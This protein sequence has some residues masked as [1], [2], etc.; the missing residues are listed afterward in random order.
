LLALVG[1]GC[2]DDGTTSTTGTT[3]PST[4]DFIQL[5][6][7]VMPGYGFMVDYFDDPYQERG[8]FTAQLETDLIPDVFSAAGMDYTKL[9][10]DTVPGGYELAVNPSLQT[11]V[12]EDWA[13]ASNTAAALGFVL[14]Q[15]SVLLTDF[16]PSDT[17]NTGYAVVTFP[18]GTLDEKIAGDFFTHAGSVNMGLGGGFA[19]FGDS[20]YFLNIT[21]D[22][23]KPYSELA[24]DVFIAELGKAATGFAGPKATV[25][26]SGRCDARFVGND[27][28]TKPMGDE[29]LAE[30]A[31]LDMAKQDELKG[32]QAEFKTAFDAAVVK[33]GWD[34][35]G[36]MPKRAP[37]PR[38][39]WYGQHFIEIKSN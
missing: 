31:E 16:T 13:A 29:Y 34:M 9:D 4:V 35:P 17:G 20:M 39:G 19:A 11:R 1:L 2:S 3:P 18:A 27:W 10:S 28:D 8:E 22:E 24:D 37:A 5:S 33:Y 25:E 38:R 7:E 12:P 21:D 32:L 26:K 23:G 30:L 15:Y 36:P 6:Y 14:F